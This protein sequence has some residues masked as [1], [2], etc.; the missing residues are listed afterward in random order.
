MLDLLPQI[1]EDIKTLNDDLEHKEQAAKI[2]ISRKFLVYDDDNDEYSIQTQEYLKKFSSAITPDLPITLSIMVDGIS[3]T[4]SGQI[5]SS[6]DES[7]SEEEIPKEEFKIFS[8]PLYDIDDE[9]I[10]NENNLLSKKD[11]DEIIPIPPGI[12]ERCFNA[13]SDLLGSLLNR[14]SPIDST[15]INSIFD[16]FSLPRPPE[17]PSSQ[18]FSQ[19]PMEEIDL[20][21]DNS[22][23]PG[24]DN[25]DSKGDILPLKELL[26]N[27]LSPLPESDDFTVDVEP[28][29]AVTNDFDVLNNDEPFDS[30][31]RVYGTDIKEMDINKDKAGQNRA[32]D[33]KER[34]KTSPAMLSDFIGPAH[35]P[36]TGPGQLKLS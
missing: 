25:D 24:I 31:G 17:I 34:E 6:D 18:S 3:N 2:S 26:D 15:K 20:F 1:D 36:L 29:A 11:L 19:I 30:G 23:P 21:L 14:D 5:I 12:D 10:T 33:R 16:E 22:I 9:I 4:H 32:R 8:N 27:V 28:V 35:N 7:L 13:E